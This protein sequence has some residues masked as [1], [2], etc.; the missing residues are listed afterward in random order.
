MQQKSA[1]TRL[2]SIESRSTLLTLLPAQTTF[3][4]LGADSSH[5]GAL[6]RRG[7]SGL[8]VTIHCE[9]SPAAPT[10]STIPPG[11]MAC[12][13]V[14]RTRETTYGAEGRGS[15]PTERAD[16]LAGQSLILRDGRDAESLS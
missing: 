9:H 3:I 1:A 8:I 2:T 4:D 13:Q 5:R 15:S 7:S 11:R 14:A 12:T 10:A 6:K 16:V